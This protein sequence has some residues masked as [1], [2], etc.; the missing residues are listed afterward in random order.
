MK[1]RVEFI[2]PPS[3]LVAAGLLLFAQPALAA[4]GG[5]GWGVLLTI[6]RFFNLALVIGVLVW[7]ARKPLAQFYASRTATI[8]EQLE[9]AQKARVEAETKLAEVES[10]MSQL[11]DELRAIKE[12]AERDGH[13]E[14]ERLVAVA[15][16]DADK[17]L[18]RARQE[19]EGMTRAAQIE[20]KAHAAELAVR[21]AEEK[22]RHDMND[23]DRNRLFDRFITRLGG[24]P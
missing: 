9:E 21:L 20:L 16:R 6:G 15:E 1:S 10:R 18:E 3:P 14:Y 24:L 7:V 2:L 13:Q 4:E 5:D 17:V 22:I 11:D 23:E 8:R 12:A 19:I